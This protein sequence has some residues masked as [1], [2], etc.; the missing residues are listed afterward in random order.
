MRRAGK[1]QRSL[2][3][4][5]AAFIEERIEEFKQQISREELLRIADEA[6]RELDAGA[7][8]Q[9]LL[10]EVLMLDHVDRLIRQR[11]NLPTFR[12]WRARHLKLRRAQRG[13]THW[14]LDARS[15]IVSLAERADLDGLALVVGSGVAPI[16]LYLAACDWPVVFV[17]AEVS[18]VEGLETRA[19]AESLG[20][21]VEAY[22]VSLGCWLPEVRPAL[23]VLDPAALARTEPAER[24]QFLHVLLERTPPGG[25]HCLVPATPGRD[26]IA[27][28]PETV[29]AY[30]AGW[31]L[32]RIHDGTGRGLIAT[33]PVETDPGKARPTESAADG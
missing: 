32:E 25:V 31:H 7:D 6:V 11:L 18:I 15:P 14:G 21:R 23:T 27:P 28:G 33:R 16:A 20:S 17:D 19:A 8:E 1:P 29:K 12:R 26:A 4:E 9:L 24:E 2:H 5:Y 3:Q 22:V 30:Y 10:T 13:P